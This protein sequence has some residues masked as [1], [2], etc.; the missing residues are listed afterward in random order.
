MRRP[1]CHACHPT[2]VPLNG[3]PRRRA[4]A[5]LT[6]RPELQ[7]V[8][9]VLT[10]RPVTV[11]APGRRALVRALEMARLARDVAV[12]TVQMKRRLIVKGAAGRIE[13]GGSRSRTHQDHCRGNRDN[14]E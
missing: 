4:V 3:R 10:T 12:S 1:E 2:V 14:A 11:E 8:A 9:I 6:L 7:P 13:L 5:R